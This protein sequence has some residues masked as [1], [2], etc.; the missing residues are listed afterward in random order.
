MPEQEQKIAEIEGVSHDPV[1][2]ITKYVLVI[3]ALIFI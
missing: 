3:T 1:G 2:K